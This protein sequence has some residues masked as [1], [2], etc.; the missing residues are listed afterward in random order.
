MY[1]NVFLPTI[2]V[3]VIIYEDKVL[4]IIFLNLKTWSIFIKYIIKNRNSRQPLERAVCNLV[5]TFQ[6]HL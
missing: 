3:M 4:T 2:T 6:P 5:I 1:I